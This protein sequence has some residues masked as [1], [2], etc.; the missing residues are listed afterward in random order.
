[1]QFGLDTCQPWPCEDNNKRLRQNRRHDVLPSAGARSRS[2]SSSTN[3]LHCLQISL[4]TPFVFFSFQ[5]YAVM[6][7]L[8]GPGVEQYGIICDVITEV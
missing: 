6:V 1:M 2:R 7:V 5:G 4:R 8:F 3:Q